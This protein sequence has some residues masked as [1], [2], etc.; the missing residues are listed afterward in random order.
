MCSSQSSYGEHM[1]LSVTNHLNPV[2]SGSKMPQI[3]MH[4]VWGVRGGPPHLCDYAVASVPGKGARLRL[5][6]PHYLASGLLKFLLKNMA[7]HGQGFCLFCSRV[8]WKWQSRICGEGGWQGLAGAGTQGHSPRLW[9]CLAPPEAWSRAT[10]TTHPQ[11]RTQ[12]GLSA[13]PGLQA[14]SCLDTSLSNKDPGCLL[15]EK[16]EGRSRKTFV[17]MPHL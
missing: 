8:E 12:E 3:Q 4:P 6:G 5:Q 11:T 14:G 7:G 1:F 13:L 9:R 17:K 10:Q 16:A 2:V 15:D